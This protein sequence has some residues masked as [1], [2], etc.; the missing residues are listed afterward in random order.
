M[1]SI[2][3]PFVGA[4]RA[5]QHR[6]AIAFKKFGSRIDL[7]F[8]F[9]L[10]FCILGGFDACTS[11]AFRT[12]ANNF[13]SAYGDVLNEQMLLNLARLD[14][15]HPA[16]FIAV[17]ALN[18]RWS[19]GATATGGVAPTDTD[20]TTKSQTKQPIGGIIGGTLAIANKMLQTVSTATVGRSVSASV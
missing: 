11:V 4:F 19:M 15:G 12:E 7:K 17:G 20:T 2:S 8:T 5:R 3:P 6:S 16:Y 18:S 9:V 13:S 10:G 1:P 14:N